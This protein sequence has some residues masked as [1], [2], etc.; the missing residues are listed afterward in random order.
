MER[1][2]SEQ[3]ESHT[4]LNSLFPLTALGKKI[5]IP[6]PQ[7]KL[8]GEAFGKMNLRSMMVRIPMAFIRLKLL[9][10]RVSWILKVKYIAHTTLDTA[11]SF[12]TDYQRESRPRFLKGSNTPPASTDKPQSPRQTARHRRVDVE[13]G[14]VGPDRAA[15]RSRQ[16]SSQATDQNSQKGKPW[17]ALKS[18]NLQLNIPCEDSYEQRHR[19]HLLLAAMVALTLQVALLVIAVSTVY[20]ISGFEPEPWGLPCFLGG[21]VLLFIGMLACSVAIEKR[22]REL[23]WYIPGKATTSK[24][25]RRSFDLLWVQRSQRVSEQD[26]GSY[27]I[28]GGSRRYV[29]TSSR[30]EDVEGLE[31]STLPEQEAV[32]GQAARSESSTG[33]QEGNVKNSEPYLLPLLPFVAVLCG[34]IGFTV[35]FIGLRGLPWPCAVSQLGAIIIMAIIRALIRHRLTRQLKHLSVLKDHELDYLAIKL[36]ENHGKVFKDVDAQKAASDKKIYIPSGQQGHILTTVLSNLRR[37]V[38]GRDDREEQP[39]VKGLVWKV[40]T[41]SGLAFESRERS[42]SATT[43]P[44]LELVFTSTG[45]T[46][47]RT[48][49]SDT[50][51]AHGF[52]DKIR[53]DA[54]YTDEGQRTILVRK[55]LSDLCKWPSSTLKPALALARSIERFMNEFFPEG[56]PT[57]P[58]DQMTWK[59]PF[60]R[61]HQPDGTASTSSSGQPAPTWVRLDIKKRSDTGGWEVDGGQIEAILSLWLAHWRA[62]RPAHL[63]AEN[64]EKRKKGQSIDWRRAGDGSSVDYCRIIDENRNGVLKRDIAWWVNNAIEGLQIENPEARDASEDNPSSGLEDCNFRIGLKWPKC[65][66]FWFLPRLLFVST[67]YA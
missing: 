66:H 64:Q 9:K 3:W 28:N 60:S 21:S 23:I 6:T 53:S 10:R 51:S 43:S 59:I 57:E 24:E 33:Q 44:E 34:G 22:T 27:V 50:N 54:V 48:T 46:G 37:M 63:E 39:L 1:E 45:E 36:V 42:G 38:G 67:N 62:H 29:M 58:S 20:F 35:Q 25:K 32:N 17:Q 15:E 5:K 61:P 4:L 14:K 7:T 18:P 52:T 65:K 40:N 31:R 47:S 13:A 8:V 30:R 16:N 55:R 49:H 26:F 41:G 12:G 2:S 19:S 11:D 56:L